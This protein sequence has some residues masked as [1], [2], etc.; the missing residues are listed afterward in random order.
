[1]KKNCSTIYDKSLRLSI[2]G[3]ERRYNN[4]SQSYTER[5]ALCSKDMN[6]SVISRKDGDICKFCKS[7]KCAYESVIDGIPNEILF[8][9]RRMIGY[10][11]VNQ[12]LSYDA[13]MIPNPDID[14]VRNADASKIAF[15]EKELSKRFGVPFVYRDLFSIERSLIRLDGESPYKVTVELRAVLAELIPAYYY[16]F[17]LKKLT[18]VRSVAEIIEEFGDQIPKFYRIIYQDLGS[19]NYD[20][21][22]RHLSP[23]AI[24]EFL[25]RY[26]ECDDP[27]DMEKFFSRLGYSN[28]KLFNEMDWESVKNMEFFERNTDL[29][30]SEKVRKR[31]YYGARAKRDYPVVASFIR[32]NFRPAL[33]PAYSPRG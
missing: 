26:N 1:M 33:V 23:V 9:V 18:D 15:I 32:K 4:L 19:V 27:K 21:Y 29:D 7:K 22:S 14:E 28:T 16:K 13:L 30:I 17:Y 6:A 11:E 10:L 3:N 31:C 20:I 5:I 8:R 24:S 25:N 2:G 12:M